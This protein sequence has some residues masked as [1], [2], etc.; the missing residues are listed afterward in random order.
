MIS[1]ALPVKLVL[2]EG[3][4]ALIGDSSTLV[5]V[6]SLVPPGNRPLIELMWT[7]IYVPHMALLGHIELMKLRCGNPLEYRASAN[8]MYLYTTGVRLLIFKQIAVNDD[9]IKWNIFRVTDPLCGEFTGPGEF[10]K[11]RPVTWSVNVSFDLRLN[12]RLSKQ[13]WG[14]WFETP[15]WSLW[16]HCNGLG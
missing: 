6:M 10:P 5:W 9:V 3:N 12:K 14:W 11:Q 4:R 13:P 1:W 15:S 16:R 8:E 7:Q 2:G